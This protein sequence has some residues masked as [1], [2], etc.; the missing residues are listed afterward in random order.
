MYHMSRYKLCF[1]GIRA[2]EEQ[3][4]WAGRSDLSTFDSDVG[5]GVVR[6][7]CGRQQCKS[8][9]TLWSEDDWDHKTI[10][11]QWDVN[12][13]EKAERN[14]GEMVVF[15]IGIQLYFQYINENDG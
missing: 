10:S 6:C 11:T 7:R 5:V 4:K 13:M 1:S 15:F 12:E 3:K 8:W 9:R 14:L 2:G